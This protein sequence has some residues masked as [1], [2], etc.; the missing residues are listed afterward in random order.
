MESTSGTPLHDGLIGAAAVTDPAPSP[1]LRI[2]LVCPYSLSRPGGVQGQVLGLARS[3]GARG[4]AVT[5]FAPVDGTGPEPEG[6]E[7]LATGSSVSLP[8]NGAMAPV[9]LS[10]RA[11]ARGVS[12]VR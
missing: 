5:V 1:P 8:A 4:H 12:S 10:P 7:V 2:A 3:L 6:I 11:I 9:T